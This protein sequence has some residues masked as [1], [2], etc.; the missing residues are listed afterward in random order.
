M[1]APAMHVGERDAA[2]GVINF[3]TILGPEAEKSGFKTHALAFSKHAQ[4][5]DET[6]SDEEAN[7]AHARFLEE[8]G[9]QP[10]ESVRDSRASSFIDLPPDSEERVVRAVAALSQN[11]VLPYVNDGEGDGSI[12]HVVPTPHMN[13]RSRGK[14][15]PQTQPV[16]PMD[17]STVNPSERTKQD[18]FWV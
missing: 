9:I 1:R 18:R 14:P 8:R 13:M 11:K 15:D 10:S 4:F 2:R 5:H 6:L 12:S 7:E 16:L 3:R 17:Y